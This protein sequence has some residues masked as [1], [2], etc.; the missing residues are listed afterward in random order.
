M[1]WSP[2]FVVSRH[3]DALTALWIDAHPAAEGATF[4]AGVDPTIGLPL[5]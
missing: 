1:G 2:G 5:P 3:G 4:G